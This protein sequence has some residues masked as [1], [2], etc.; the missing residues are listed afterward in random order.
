MQQL[1]IFDALNDIAIENG[2]ST[3]KDDVLKLIDKRLN[4]IGIK[5]HFELINTKISLRTCVDN[6]RLFV[7]LL[8]TTA[9]LNDVEIYPA[10]PELYDYFATT[11]FSTVD[12]NGMFRDGIW[13]HP[14]NTIVYCQFRN[15]YHFYDGFYYDHKD[16]AEKCI[17]GIIKTGF[18]KELVN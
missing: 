2:R 3:F 18:K 11:C 14:R 1:T 17:Q 12:Q 4:D 7:T 8:S 9:Y 5:E 13:L 6:E 15:D 10:R 16:V